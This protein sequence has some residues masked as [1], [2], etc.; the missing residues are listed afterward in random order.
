MR[1]KHVKRSSTCSGLLLLFACLLFLSPPFANAA[2]LKVY[3]FGDSLSDSGNAYAITAGVFPPSPPYAQRETNGPVAV[4]WLATQLG[5]A[6][7]PSV[8]GG[9]N[10]AVA[11][12]STGTSN[13]VSLASLSNTGMQSQ[14]AA[15]GSTA[16]VIDPQSSLFFVWGGTNDFLIALNNFQNPLVAAAQ[17]ITNLSTDIGLLASLGAKHFF[18]P[19]LPDFGTTP[20]GQAIDSA[21]LSLISQGF[22]A[23]LANALGNLE[24]TLNIDIQEFD[25]YGLLHSVLANP[26]AFGFTNVTDPCFNGITV[27][28]NPD[29]YL[30][31]DSG[32]PSA[33]AHQIL[34]QAFFA[35]LPVPSAVSE[36]NI[37]LLLGCALLV[38]AYSR[39]Y[40]NAVTDC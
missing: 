38:L 26:S 16:P 21:L 39:R 24:T 17:A 1:A 4:E 27:C 22:N 9:T 8:F 30:F 6:F 40:P 32:H 33:R 14:I 34:G 3:A 31:W 12:A 37:G 23:A 5:I 15:F 18:V 10:Y 20:F 25:V 28:P 35:A 13:S 29:Q 11:G 19:N 7:A 36:P 2:L